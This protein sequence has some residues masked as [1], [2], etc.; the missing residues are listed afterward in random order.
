MALP[1]GTWWTA[2]M[3]AACACY[4]VSLPNRPVLSW[5]WK[6]RV[7]RVRTRLTAPWAAVSTYDH[8]TGAYA[9]V[10]SGRLAAAPALA[11][12]E[13]RVLVPPLGTGMEGFRGGRTGAAPTR[14][15]YRNL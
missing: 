5:W 13:E 14:V 9:D 10:A 3:R 2:G 15:R 8:E 7:E 1:E 11:V 6:L 12:G 4:N